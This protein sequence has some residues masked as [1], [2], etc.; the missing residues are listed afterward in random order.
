MAV[1]IQKRCRSKDIHEAQK[2]RKFQDIQPGQALAAVKP[3]PHRRPADQG[4]ARVVADGKTDQGCRNN[5]LWRY[6]PA[7]IAKR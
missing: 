4:L 5:M 7:Q 6:C 3:I 1:L 2:Q